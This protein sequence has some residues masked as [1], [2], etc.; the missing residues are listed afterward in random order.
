MS[1]SIQ[2]ISFSPALP[3]PTDTIY[4]YVD[5]EFPNG[6]CPLSNSSTGTV[7]NTVFASSLHC[8]GML[9][10]ICNTTDTF[11]VEPLPVG[12]Y[13]F[14]MT[15]SSGAGPVPCS[16]GIVPNDNRTASFVVAN[17]NINENQTK[18][19]VEIS[20]NPSSG[21]Y[22]LNNI[23]KKK[24]FVYDVLGNQ[25]LNHTTLSKYYQLDLSSYPRGMYLLK[26]V[27]NDLI[28]T[29]RLLKK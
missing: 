27:S 1:Q 13:T 25:L 5:L 14:D 20:P 11:M 3:G 18:L 19:N 10:V 7:G 9:Q 8:V 16:P 29:H 12:N 28:E 17:L 24:L 23:N 22:M 2:N 15:L 6:S 21:I 26:V 4:F